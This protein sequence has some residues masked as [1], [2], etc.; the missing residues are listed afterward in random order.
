MSKTK[1]YEILLKLCTQVPFYLKKSVYKLTQSG[2]ALLPSTVYH[3][4][5]NTV[6]NV[7][8]F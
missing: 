8:G 1:I 6:S 4:S 7:H 3:K 5:K 2:Y